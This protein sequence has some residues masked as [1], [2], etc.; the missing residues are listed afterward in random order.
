MLI[1][2]CLICIMLRMSL[3]QEVEVMYSLIELKG[4]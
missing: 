4:H 1:L 2:N 3:N